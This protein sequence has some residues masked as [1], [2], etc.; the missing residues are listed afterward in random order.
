MEII[1]KKKRWDLLVPK[2]LKFPDGCIRNVLIE[3]NEE[4]IITHYKQIKKIQKNN[5]LKWM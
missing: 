5:I 2:D 4:R 1:Y 3:R